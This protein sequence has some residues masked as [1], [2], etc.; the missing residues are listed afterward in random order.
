MTDGLKHVVH[1]RVHLERSQPLERR[2]KVGKF[3]EKKR[4]YKL[5]AERYHV[6]E[7]RIR[8]LAAKTRFRNEDEFNFKMVHGKLGE[9]GVVVL[10]SKEAVAERKLDRKGKFKKTL[11]SI[12]QNRF[13]LKHRLNI[14][15]KRVKKT[16]TDNATLLMDSG[17]HKVF[18]DSEESH[19][20]DPEEAS[21][22]SDTSDREK[23]EGLVS[24]TSLERT[25]KSKTSQ[26]AKKTRVPKRTPMSKEIQ[27]NLKIVG[28]TINEKRT[29]S[30]LQQKLDDER[31]LRSALYRKRQ[32]R[33]V[34]NT[35]TRVYPFER[36]K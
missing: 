13:V 9:D 15:D 7:R 33:R 26:N 5:R 12:D 31:H 29:D 20:S 6:M 16:M 4:D 30:Q 22:G 24:S 2:K 3:L 34:A 23:D 21:Q 19:N 14:K 10:P 25:A 27:E 8:D 32:V 18:D 17:E 1:R 11:S 35:N 28:Q 36:Q